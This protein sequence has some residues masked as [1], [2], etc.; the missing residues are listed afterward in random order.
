[1]AEQQEQ[2]L[3]LAYTLFCDD[4]RLEVGNKLSYMGVFQTI[5]VPQLFDHELHDIELTKPGDPLGWPPQPSV[6]TL[7][8]IHAEEHGGGY[9]RI[10]IPSASPAGKPKSIPAADAAN[11]DTGTQ[12]TVTAIGED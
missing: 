2:K 11:D 12:S 5:M 4:V 3:E 1:M 6:E 10:D 7:T 8:G 9:L